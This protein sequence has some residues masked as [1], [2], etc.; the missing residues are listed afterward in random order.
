MSVA[1][2]R[3]ARSSGIRS[4][5]TSRAISKMPTEVLRL[6]LS[7]YNLMTTG[8]R[9]QLARRLRNHFRARPVDESPASDAGLGSSESEHSDGDAGR[10]AP[11]EGGSGSSEPGPSV[12]TA[13]RSRDGSDSS[14]PEPSD[15]GDTSSTPEDG[16]TRP[17][18]GNTFRQPRSVRSRR[19]RLPRRGPHAGTGDRTRA[20]RSSRR[21]R[22]V[23]SASARHF[24]TRGGHKDNHHHR[25]SRRHSS[26][27]STRRAHTPR[28]RRYRSSSSFSSSSSSSS[29]SESP[30][31]GRSRKRQRTPASRMTDSSSA[32]SVGRA[33]RYKRRRHCRRSSTSSASLDWVQPPNVC[34]APPL[35]RR[36][37]NRIKQG[38]FHK[39]LPPTDTPPVVAAG[40]AKTQRH[41]KKET[42][43]ITD[44][45]SWLEA[46][47]RYL[48]ARLTFHPSMALELA[49][50]QTLMA[51]LFANYPAAAC[52]HYDRLFRYAASQDPSLRWDTV[53]EDVYV[54]CLTR[55]A[56]SPIPTPGHSTQDRRPGTYLPFRDRPPI[57]SRLGPPTNTPDRVT[58]TATGREIC[59]RYNASR[60]TRGDECLFAH[61][62]WVPGCYGAHPAKGCPKRPP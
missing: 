18:P 38:K 26:L 52:L 57:S 55:R 44:L 62:C 19:V 27:R 32:S 56:P 17:A 43:T 3:P 8:R 2:R 12:G 36:W 41:K 9:D 21:N 11:P 42:R 13:G 16:H 22:T 7:N 30:E 53:K 60:C 10:P 39:L 61:I 29:S 15:D 58:H 47:N 54:W 33:H 25:S 35:P 1:S 20:S 48:C 28:H 14:E 34:C 24:T 4:I 31:R 46:W 23:H 40:Q 5:P 59:R 37:V 51:M 45:A 49:K 50:Y 6:H